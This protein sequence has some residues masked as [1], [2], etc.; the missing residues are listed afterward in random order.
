[1]HDPAEGTMALTLTG[2]ALL[3]CLILTLRIAGKPGMGW[4][5]V[6]AEAICLGLVVFAGVW[7]AWPFFHPQIV[8]LGD[9][10]HYTLQIADAVTQ[11]RSGVFPVFVGQSVYAFNG[12]VHTLRTAPYFTNLGIFLDLLTAR[13]LPFPALANLTL[14]L[15]SLGGALAAYACARRLLSG[16]RAVSA[17]LAV[18]YTLGPGLSVPAIHYDLFATYLTAPWQPIFWLGLALSLRDTDDREGLFWSV[19]ALGTLWSV[20]PPTAIWLTPAF[21]GTQMARLTFPSSGWRIQINRWL[22]A[23]L[24]LGLLTVFP[25]YSVLSLGLGY[26]PAATGGMEHAIIANLR[27][28][29]PG[30]LLPFASATGHLQ[31]LQLGYSLWALLAVGFAFRWRSGPNGWILKLCAVGYLLLL[32]PVPGLTLWLWQQM[33]PRILDMTNVWPM[34]RFYLILSGLAAV[35]S[36]LFFGK[37][38][39][40]RPRAAPYLIALLLVAV[41]WSASEAYRFR[42][43]G[44]EVRSTAATTT[45]LLAPAN[46]NAGRSSYL[47][48]G[49]YPAHFSHGRMDPEFE[50]RLVDA[51]SNPTVV[52]SQKI[53]AS[54]VAGTAPPAWQTIQDETSFQVDGHNDIL[55]EFAFPSADAAGYIVVKG[56][57]VEIAYEIPTFGEPKAFGS[58][59]ESNP[60]IVARFR[61]EPPQRVIIL[62]KPPG[63]RVRV[64]PFTS[65]RD[66]P[67][68]L[69]SLTPLKITLQDPAPAGTTLETPRMFIPGYAARVDGR[70]TAVQ[71]LPDGLAG[72]PLPAGSREII[73][74]YPGPIGL[75]WCYFATLTV[76]C[77]L[78][79]GAFLLGTG[80]YRP[81]KA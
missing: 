60:T 41:A 17:L 37:L 38:L 31:N 21:I 27:A 13:S 55:L 71:R 42:K 32:L 28:A 18:T 23:A 49:H 53:L 19:F 54:A 34:Q 26:S 73:V 51:N 81:W 70:P 58:K 9:A 64:W 29:W 15:S 39:R 12:G 30:S 40:E 24:G 2:L 8:G 61:G 44:F 59:P 36:A 63:T 77:L 10:T 20:H 4:R 6:L 25:F 66:V 46:L 7:V 43:R 62:S 57:T 50:L 68:R 22:I 65:D 1:M 35:S 72:V 45:R 5:V 80:L 48:F 69:T 74:D 67:I 11:A 56:Q 16:G 47:L 78:T 14:V 79:A 52:N 33:P 75:R 76:W 3:G